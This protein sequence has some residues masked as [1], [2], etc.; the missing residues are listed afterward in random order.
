MD[1][2]R[3]P[4]ART[5]STQHHQ[6]FLRRW[7]VGNIHSDESNDR[8]MVLLPTAHD[9]RRQIG[10]GHG[11]GVGVQ[12]VYVGHLDLY[13]TANASTP[14]VGV[15]GTITPRLPERKRFR[16][17]TRC[18]AARCRRGRAPVQVSGKR[19]VGGTTGSYKRSRRSDLRRGCWNSGLHGCGCTDA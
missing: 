1:A 12:F 16:L 19:V 15:I 6:Q 5:Q 9:G 2:T 14:F 3:S 18:L 7:H 17:L 8:L 13:Y 4:A 10:K 11:N